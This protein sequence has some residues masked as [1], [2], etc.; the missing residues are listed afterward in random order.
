MDMMQDRTGGQHD[1]PGRGS[2]LDRVLRKE[3]DTV[4]ACFPDVQGRL[5]GKHV[6]ADY[7]LR[8]QPS[9]MGVCDY[10]LALDLDLTP[11]RGIAHSSWELGYGD[12]FMVPDDT[13]WRV[14]PWAERTAMVM[15]D[16]VG[17][18]GAPVSV[19]PRTILKRQ[20]ALLQEL[21]LQA[22][23]PRNSSSTP[24]RRTTGRHTAAITPS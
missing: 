6:T 24:S 22:S 14:L 12:M 7:Y 10:L 9:P 20:L 4:I 2:L 17:R 16:L 11:L 18:D 23:L 21:G 1:K 13:A 5:V 8:S 3:F 19:S 15:C